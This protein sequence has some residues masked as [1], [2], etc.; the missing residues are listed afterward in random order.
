MSGS[1]AVKNTEIKHFQTGHMVYVNEDALKQ[2]HD[3]F[4]QLRLGQRQPDQG[5]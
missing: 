5:K 2:L 3:G 1:L 4:A